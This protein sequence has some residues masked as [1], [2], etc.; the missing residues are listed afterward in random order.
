L[1]LDAESNDE[2]RAGRVSTRRKSRTMGAT[3]QV[4]GLA[5]LPP[6]YRQ[7]SRSAPIFGEWQ[8]RAPPRL[9]V[10]QAAQLPRAHGPPRS[11]TLRPPA[12]VADAG[13]A[14]PPRRRQNRKRP[15]G[16]PPSS[17]QTC[18]RA[19]LPAAHRR[20]LPPRTFPRARPGSSPMSHRGRP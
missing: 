19:E 11:G 16:D 20:G 1:P 5:W 14:G 18:H 17:K 13:P 12:P 3:T 15:L 2:V 7:Q 6:R 4:G 9:P 10:K 8:G